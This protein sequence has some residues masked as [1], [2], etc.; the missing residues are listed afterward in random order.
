MQN[1]NMEATR[2]VIRL[3]EEMSTDDTN[4]LIRVNSLVTK[5]K[6]KTN[7]NEKYTIEERVKDIMSNLT[8]EL[9]DI[10]LNMTPMEVLTMKGLTKH[11]RRLNHIYISSV[12]REILKYIK[13]ELPTIHTSKR[14]DA[15]YKKYMSML[16]A[17]K[18]PYKPCHVKEL[19]DTMVGD[20]TKCALGVMFSVYFLGH[21]TINDEIMFA[22]VLPDGVEDAQ[23]AYVYPNGTVE[24]HDH[25]NDK[26][27]YIQ[28][29]LLESK[30]EPYIRGFIAG[31]KCSHIVNIYCEKLT[32]YMKKTYGT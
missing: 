31:Q 13:R 9:R 19:L 28:H 4:E 17:N 8:S 11:D 24:I 27:I 21:K 2:Q 20:I 16:I 14:E 5:K 26:S 18:S 25:V 30:I 12:S 7:K 29:H 6:R 22:H 32:T 3:L 1:V 10:Y 15:L 23:M